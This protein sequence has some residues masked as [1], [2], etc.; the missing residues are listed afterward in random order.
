M[1]VYCPNPNCADRQSTSH[2]GVCATCGTHLTVRRYQLIEPLRKLLTSA[3]TEV[4]MVKDLYSSDPKVMKILRTHN[5]VSSKDQKLLQLFDQEAAVLQELGHD[6]IPKMETDGYF[7]FQ[8]ATGLELKCLVM[9]KITG[10]NLEQ[11]LRENHCCPPD[12]ALQ[13]LNQIIDILEYLHQHQLFH[14]DI[15]PANI[16][17]KPNGQLAL[18]DFGAVR[19]ITA[20][21][22][23]TENL[24]AIFTLGYAPPEQLERQAVPQSDFYALGRTFVHLLTGQN[25]LHFSVSNGRLQWRYQSES[26][27]FKLLAELVDQLMTV[28]VEERP[29]SAI[30]IRQQI[31]QIEHKNSKSWKI[32]FA[33][34]RIFTLLVAVPFLTLS[35]SG[36]FPANPV[37][38][39]I[40][41]GEKSLFPKGLTPEKQSGIAAFA[42]EN[43]PQAIKDFQAVLDKDSDDSEA[44]IFLHNARIGSRKSRTIAVRVSPATTRKAKEVGALSGIAKILN[45]SKYLEKAAVKIAILRD[46]DLSNA[47]K[48]KAT[49][50]LVRQPDVVGVIVVPSKPSQLA[51]NDIYCNKLVNITL[52][53]RAMNNQ[54]SQCKGF[55]FHLAPNGRLEAQFL[56]KQISKMRRQRVAILFWSE[57]LQSNSTQSEFQSVFKKQGGQIVDELDMSNDSIHIS[58]KKIE[59]ALNKAEAIV[60]FP[61]PTSFADRHSNNKFLNVLKISR[62]K[63]PMLGGSGAFD[64]QLLKMTEKIGGQGKGIIVTAPCCHRISR[65]GYWQNTLTQDAIKVFFIALKQRPSRN[66]IHQVISSPNF[67][68]E[69]KSGQ[70]N[71]S[72][73]GDRLI[74]PEFVQI[75]PNSQS[76]FGYDFV[77]LK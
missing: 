33:H 39:F 67:Q 14:R 38:P 55:A 62:Q 56:T 17:L 60:V 6:G 7:S 77:P 74:N 16:M 23:G 22:Q 64:Q 71:F 4:F 36:F 5:Q 27:S 51:V 3:C 25:P 12:L 54:N 21:V 58:T 63:L 53:S 68:A 72:S 47:E 65:S 52:I 46:S 66:G 61:T 42:Q 30:L 41:Y 35:G 18:V 1:M 13:W 10:V 70:I 34:R 75:S 59:E 31:K 8:T 37:S 69:G 11:W 40:T 29:Q 15:K 24:T 28:V 50:D 20:T 73:V 2:S 57:D 48:E 76:Q 45:S 49:H 9:E 26:Y 19:R 32:S 44:Q 43:Y